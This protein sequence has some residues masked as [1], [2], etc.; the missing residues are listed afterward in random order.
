MSIQTSAVTVLSFTRHQANT[1][2]CYLSTTPVFEWDYFVYLTRDHKFKDH[3]Y[4]RAHSLLE[5]Q[6]RRRGLNGMPTAAKQIRL[7]KRRYEAHS[8]KAILYGLALQE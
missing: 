6:N 5:V 1:C 3:G 4:A 8:A 2:W 7:A